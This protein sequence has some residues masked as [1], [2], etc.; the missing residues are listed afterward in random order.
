M[1]SREVR[2][3]SDMTFVILTRFQVSTNGRVRH[4]RSHRS[5]L[6]VAVGARPFAF[7][8]LDDVLAIC[9]AL[10]RLADIRIVV[11][12]GR[13]PAGSPPPHPPAG[14][15]IRHGA[16]DL[17]DLMTR[18]RVVI[19]RPSG[20]TVAEAISAGAVPLPLPSDV[21]WEAEA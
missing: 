3:F 6:R 20:A 16:E 2:A 11:C 13:G 17:S 18:A 10:R 5:A 14:I 12:T 21:P 15:E 9:S 19:T 4:R 1:R 7:V 8:P